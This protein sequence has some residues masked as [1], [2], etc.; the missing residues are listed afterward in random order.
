MHRQ[1]KQM[2]KIWLQKYNKKRKLTNKTYKIMDFTTQMINRDFRINMQEF[3]NGTRVRHLI[4]V[5]TL[6]E[7]IGIELA[8]KFVHRA[9]DCGA[10]SCIC[11]LRRGLQISFY[12]K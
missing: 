4:G 12:S 3:V 10:D 8:N 7:L 1:I 5:S 11:K 9:Y 6:I 2:L